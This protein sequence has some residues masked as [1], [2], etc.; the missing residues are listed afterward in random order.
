[1]KNHIKRVYTVYVNNLSIGIVRQNGKKCYNHPTY[2]SVKRLSFVLDMHTYRG[3]A[4]T[5][6][7]L[8]AVNAPMVQWYLPAFFK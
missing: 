5:T 1:M 3:I 4:K 2:S 8:S 7:Q 6:V